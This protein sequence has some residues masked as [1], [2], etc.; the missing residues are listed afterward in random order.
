MPKRLDIKKLALIQ[1]EGEKLYKQQFHK[2][3]KTIKFMYLFFLL[4]CMNETSLQENIY[5]LFSYIRCTTTIP[6]TLLISQ[7]KVPFSNPYPYGI[8]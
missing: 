2:R 5:F 1:R 4:L 8:A 6:I 3:Q 7:R